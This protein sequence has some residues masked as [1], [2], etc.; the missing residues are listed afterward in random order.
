M[1]TKLHGVAGWALKIARNP[2][3]RPVEVWALRAGF[4]FV[5]VKLGVDAS[6][7]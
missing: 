5:A 4:A 2:V 1:K 7:L 6:K 3:L